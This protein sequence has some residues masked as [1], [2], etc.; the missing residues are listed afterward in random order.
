M[1]D[2]NHKVNTPVHSRQ[3]LKMKRSIDYSLW[4][5]SI[6]WPSLSVSASSAE[7]Y[8]HHAFGRR[9]TIA[10]ALCGLD[11]AGVVAPTFDQDLGFAQRIEDL[12]VEHFI[13]EAGI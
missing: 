11:W 4:S 8:R 5:A 13:S 12:A 6:A 10:R 3:L 2:L 1:G 7:V 9:R